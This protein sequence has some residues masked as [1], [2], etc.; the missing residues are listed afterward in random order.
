MTID[1]DKCEMSL[2]AFP[3]ELETIFENGE[4]KT[5]YSLKEIRER[6]YS[7]DPTASLFLQL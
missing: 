7:Q 3:S 4:I 5:T 6:L 1:R 2:M